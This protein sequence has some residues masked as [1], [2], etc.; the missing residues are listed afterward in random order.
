[1]IFINLNSTVIFPKNPRTYGDVLP[2]VQEIKF[3]VL[4]KIGMKLVGY[5]VEEIIEEEKCIIV[6]ED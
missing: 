5:D 4:N 3:P 1:L 6:F 2:N